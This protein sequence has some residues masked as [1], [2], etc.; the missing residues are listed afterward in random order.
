MVSAPIALVL[1]LQVAPSPPVAPASPP[2]AAPVPVAS[3]NR[4]APRPVAAPPDPDAPRPAAPSDLAAPPDA[5]AR[6]VTS[7]ELAIPR[8]VAA[9]PDPGAPHPDE[10]THRRLVFAHT[11][12]LEFGA[13]YP[14]PSGALAMFLGSDL[15][16][17]LD[18]RRRLHRAALGYQLTL[19]LGRADLVYAESPGSRS[20]S[21][22]VTHRHAL[23]LLGRAGP[24]ERLFHALAL[25]AV[26]AGTAPVGLDGELRLG[27]VFPARPGRRAHFVLGGQLRLGA[28]FAGPLLPQFGGFL[29]VL[30]L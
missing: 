1:A 20:L 6:P 4:A 15:R 22:L 16:P 18:R 27:H 8:P 5:A 9:P 19:A 17:R 24:R 3:P 21:G 29:G 23:A 11:L 30:V 28:P 14:V 10:L 25:A 2:P 26:F 13:R 7:P 12:A